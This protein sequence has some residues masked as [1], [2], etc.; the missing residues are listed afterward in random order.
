MQRV[1]II[2]VRPVVA[3]FFKTGG[4][5]VEIK[6]GDYVIYKKDTCQIK[7]IKKNKFNNNDYLVLRPIDDESLKI[8]IPVATSGE[9]LRKPIDKAEVMRLI[10]RIP[11]IDVI[12]CNEKLIEAEYKNLLSSGSHEDL[13]KI[14]KTTYL[15][16]KKRLDNKKKIGDKDNYYF[17]K[18][19]RYLYNEFS[20]SL[21]MSFENAKDYITEQV[22]S[23][24]ENK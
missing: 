14:I 8:E 16:N 22:A 10:A 19:E 4:F 5:I 1:A 21:N 2:G 6:I 12:S 9:L 20:I 11:E 3:L 7:E 18:A 15:R 13:I 17:K 24:V 23:L